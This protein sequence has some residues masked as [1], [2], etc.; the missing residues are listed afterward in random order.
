MNAF[1]Y[2]RTIRKPYGL[3]IIRQDLHHQH[4]FGVC[5]RI[6]MC[7]LTLHDWA[8]YD[9]FSLD[10]LKLRRRLAI[11]RENPCFDKTFGRCKACGCFM[12]LKG[13]I[14]SARCPRGYWR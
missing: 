5:D 12:R 4:V 2:I 6:V 14:P 10:S 1:Y 8:I 13:R 3:N 7:L 11:C 9:R